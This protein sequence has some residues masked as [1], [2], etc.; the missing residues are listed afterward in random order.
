MLTL[1][2]TLL[3]IVIVVLTSLL[4]VVG[5]QLVFILKEVRKTLVHVNQVLDQADHAIARITAPAQ[6]LIHLVDGL[7][8]GAKLVE[9]VAKRLPEKK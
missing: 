8:Q 2:Q 5:V 6:T 4:T 9:L 1:T 7:K 3:I